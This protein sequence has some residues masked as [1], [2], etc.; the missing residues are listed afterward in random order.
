MNRY[1]VLA[2]AAIPLGAQSIT[3]LTARLDQS[4]AAFAGAKADV[5][6][7]TYNATI[8]MTDVDNGTIIVR[9]SSPGKVDFRIDFVGDNAYSFIV[10]GKLADY[11]HPQINQADVYDIDKRY[12]E[13]AQ[14]LM[15]LGF[16]MSG[17]SLQ[18][19]YTIANVRHENVA[20]QSATAMDLTPKSA[21]LTE[22][23]HMQ[24]VELWISDNSSAPLKEKVYLRDGGASTFE[25]SNIQMNV[26][27]PDSAF[28]L[29]KNTKRVKQN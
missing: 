1:L 12:R 16:G 29:P 21:E 24:K 5:R 7:S 15:A 22:Q 4:A 11:Y 3:E 13:L 23:I 14:G 19:N 10:R 6:R 2:V 8:H 18:A 20:G 9:R 27:I 17:K 28:D 25:Y 26:K